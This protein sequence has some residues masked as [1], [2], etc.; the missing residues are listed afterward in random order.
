MIWWVWHFE[1]ERLIR[2]ERERLRIE[3]NNLCEVNKN[4]AIVQILIFWRDVYL[5][6]FRPTLLTHQAIR[7][8]KNISLFR[9]LFLLAIKRHSV[10]STSNFRQWHSQH[11]VVDHQISSG[12]FSS[13]L[14]LNWLD[15]WTTLRHRQLCWCQITILVPVRGHMLSLDIFFSNFDNSFLLYLVSLSVFFLPRF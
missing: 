7:L 3:H 12:D 9:H 6:C 11:S 13:S 15:L 10:E 1:T 2:W 14:C 8:N 4:R 5:F